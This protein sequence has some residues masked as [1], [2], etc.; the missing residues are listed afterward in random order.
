MYLEHHLTG[1]ISGQPN[2]TGGTIRGAF[3][4]YFSAFG[5]L[6][7]NVLSRVHRKATIIA[8]G[9]PDTNGEYF[10]VLKSMKD[11]RDHELEFA[12]IL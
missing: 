8:F 11:T 6:K 1:L 5:T 4:G 7:G 10:P 2:A 9:T 12:S 3:R